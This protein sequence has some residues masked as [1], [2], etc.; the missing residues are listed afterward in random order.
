M[1]E[2]VPATFD[3]AKRIQLRWG[4]ACEVAAIGLSKE[5][6]IVQSMER[7][8]WAETYLVDGQVAAIVGLGISA[9]IGGHGVP[10]LLTGPACEK[11][12]RRFM[13]ESRRQVERMLEQVSPLINYVHADYSRAVRWLGWLGFEIDEPAGGFRRIYKEAV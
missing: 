7:S 11:N 6:A 4:D 10:W 5:A 9:M 1:I 13:V 8:L 2:L 3:H 12:K